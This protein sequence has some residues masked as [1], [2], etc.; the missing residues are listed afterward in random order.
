MKKIDLQPNKDKYYSQLNNKLDPYISCQVTSMVMGLDIAGY[1]LDPI[2]KLPCSKDY[3]PEDKLRWFM[4]NDPVVQ[5]Y[6]RKN[7][8]NNI[9]APEW[10][11]CMVFAVN[12][13]YNE[14]I[15]YFDDVLT[16]EEIIEDLE[17]GLPIYISMKFPDNKNFSGKP[18]PVD[19]HIV[20]IVGIQEDSI[21][22]NDPYKN[23][24]TGDRDGFKNIYNSAQ[25]TKHA[26]NYAIRYKVIENLDDAAMELGKNYYCSGFYYEN[27]QCL[28]EN[29]P[30]VPLSCSGACLRFCHRKWP[31]PEQF[32]HEYSMDYP[33]SGAVYTSLYHENDE[34]S[35]LEWNINTL[36][37]AKNLE[38][39]Q[40]S[41]ALFY[42][43]CACTPWGKPP[44]DWK[45]S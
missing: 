25:Y 6:W 10:A 24:L 12:R 45:P 16:Q 13:L 40:D 4:L 38:K 33:D 9:P 32:K 31:T 19:G 36:A 20:L 17:K 34:E 37:G 39:S 2:N 44:E 3:Q 23:H 35:N 22:I 27:G 28:K 1:N 14:R 42:T 11:P 26:K 8:N 18:S 5:D 29:N 41:G 43:V 30:D 15:V 7:F 21:L